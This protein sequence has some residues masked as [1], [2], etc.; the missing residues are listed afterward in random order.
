MADR[1][2]QA[3]GPTTDDHGWGRGVVP[4]HEAG[5]PAGSAG[6]PAVPDAPAAP[7]EAPEVSPRPPDGAPDHVSPDHGANGDSVTTDGPDGDGAVAAPPTPPAPDETAGDEPVQE[8]G[9]DD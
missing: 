2:L 3:A 9:D 5:T 8:P 6:A 1:S 4:G 7:D